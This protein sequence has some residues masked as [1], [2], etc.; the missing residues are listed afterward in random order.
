VINTSSTLSERTQ[1]TV[2][3]VFGVLLPEIRKERAA[4]EL[5]SEFDFVLLVHSHSVPFEHGTR[6]IDEFTAGL[7]IAL[8]PDLGLALVHNREALFDALLPLIEKGEH[9]ASF[10]D[11]SRPD[12]TLVHIHYVH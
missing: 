5:P 1:H 12:A 8:P 9:D 3:H 7:P 4:C 11:Y 10:T 6:F 2:E